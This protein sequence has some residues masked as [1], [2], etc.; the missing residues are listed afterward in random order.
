MQG[1][2]IPFPRSRAERERNHD[3]RKSIEERYHD[4]S[5]YLGLVSQAAIKLIDQGYLLA[6]DLP[7]I[8][9]QA[10]ERWDYAARR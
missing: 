6:G 10:E 5:Q 1:S 4:R 2:Y 9:K 3:P 7:G 8:L